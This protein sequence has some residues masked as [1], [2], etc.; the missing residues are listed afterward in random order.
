M[1]QEC[2]AACYMASTVRKGRGR[3][4]RAQIPFS[5]LHVFFFLIC[6]YIWICVWICAHESRCS[7]RPEVSDAFGSEVQGGCELLNMES[8]T[9][10][11]VLCKSNT[12]SLQT[13]SLASFLLFILSKTPDRRVALSTPRVGLLTLTHS[14]IFF[15]NMLQ[16]ASPRSSRPCHI[17]VSVN[18]FNPAPHQL[19]TL[20]HHFQ[21]II[22]PFLSP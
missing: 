16:G 4:V 14:K 19:Y 5:S 18:H 20:N 9:Q 21:A 6:V 2:E 22:L 8:R 12:Y 11:L 7:Q 3:E 10:T 1:W 15:T 13:I 17:D